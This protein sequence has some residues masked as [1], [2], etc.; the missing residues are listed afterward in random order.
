MIVFRRWTVLARR[1]LVVPVADAVCVCLFF[2]GRGG[3]ATRFS[4]VLIEGAF[5]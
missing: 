5:V 4:A 3:K 2:A 1:R